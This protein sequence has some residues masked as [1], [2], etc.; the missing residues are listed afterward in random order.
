MS[1]THN[2]E[3][4]FSSTPMLHPG[5]RQLFRYWEA[6]RA[7]RPCPDRSEIDLRQLIEIMPNIVILEA[8][9]MLQTWQYRL[10]GTAVCDLFDGSQTGRNALDGWD[11]FEQGM[12]AKSFGIAHARKQP[13]LVQMR[14]VYESAPLVSAEL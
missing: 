7:E 4:S 5:S 14:I 3:I 9:S 13:C 1:I 2:P 6:L 10:A 11:R 8:N 12:V